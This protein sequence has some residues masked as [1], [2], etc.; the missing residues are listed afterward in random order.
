MD[1]STLYNYYQKSSG[2]CT[3]TRE[4]KKDCL[5]F[6]LKGDNFNGNL[7]VQEALD[8]GASYAVID[9]EAAHKDSGETILVEDALLALQQLAQFHRKELGIRI[10]ALTGSNGKTTTK[11]LLYALLSQKYKTSA[12]KGNLNNHIGV[13]LTLLSMTKDTEIGIV[14]MGANHLGEIKM[15]TDIAQPDYGYITNFGKAHLEGFGSMEGVIRGKTELYS[16]LK[17]H[18]K[19]VFINEL[20]PT[21]MKV[22]EG[23]KRITLGTPQSDFD[24]TLLD[25]SNQLLIEFEKTY[26][27]SKLVGAYNFANLAAAIAIGAYFA[28]ST[29]QIKQGIES[30]SPNNNRSQMLTKKTNTILMDAYNANPSSMM[31]AL[32]NFKNTDAPNKILY[33]GDMFELGNDAEMEHQ[34]IVDFLIKNPIGNVYLVGENFFKTDTSDSYLKKFQNFQELKTEIENNPPRHASILIKGSRGMAL[35][36]ILDII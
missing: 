14:E 15:L 5:F 22:S 8:K 35:E 19:E 3:D 11:E 6:A 12:T 2:V 21:Q 27:Q 29:D 31:A 1:I 33:L 26:I 28:V 13:P 36:R 18:N 25:S 9:E 7:F 10:I 24:I 32:E 23:M 20:D 30:Y 17:E 16:F 34:N 4:I